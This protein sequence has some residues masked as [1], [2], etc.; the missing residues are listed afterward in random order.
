MLGIELTRKRGPMSDSS[1]C[2][3]NPSNATNFPAALA[4]G[5]EFSLSIKGAVNANAQRQASRRTS[6]RS[7]MRVVLI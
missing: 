5:S 4:G 1:F 2:R 3:P 6:C 7:E